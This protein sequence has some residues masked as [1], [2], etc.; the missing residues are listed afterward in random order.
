[1]DSPVI[2]EIVARYADDAPFLWILRDQARSAPH[3]TA[4]EFAK[5]DSRLDAN[6]DGLRIAGADGVQAVHDEFMKYPEPGEAF[7]AAVLALERGGAADIITMLETISDPLSYRGIISAI[8]WV[9]PANVNDAVRKFLEHNLVEARMLGCAAFSVRRVSPKDMLP[10]FLEDAPLVRARGL[11]M[12]G[13]FGR[14]DLEPQLARA[15]EDEDPD[16]RFWAAWSAVL[17]GNRAGA[18][19]VLK[20]IAGPTALGW[21]SLD[22]LLRALKREEAVAWLRTQFT[23]DHRLLIYGAGVIGDATFVPWLIDKMADPGLGRLAGESLGMITGVDLEAS[24]LAG[25]SPD[26]D[27]IEEVDDGSEWI[28]SWQRDL[29]FPDKNRVKKWWKSQS[30]AENQKLLAGR[31]ISSDWLTHLNRNG[32]QRMRRAAALEAALTS[33]MP[34]LVN[35]SQRLNAKSTFQE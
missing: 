35:P 8:G 29:P 19:D 16:C 22:I 24:S 33:A 7:V 20:G 4:A 25:D 27:A 9:D 32:S 17:L 26:D 10:G 28:E 14:T 30:I 21:R 2:P 18:C 11:R 13:E 23:D 1:M 3:Y 31:P 34:I 12:V 6:I 5:L 15:F